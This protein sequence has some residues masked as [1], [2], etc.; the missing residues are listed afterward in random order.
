[1][2]SIKSAKL[3]V[4]LPGCLSPY[5]I[6]GDKLRL[7]ILLSIADNI[8]CSIALTVG[9]EAS[10]NNNPR[11]KERKY[12]PL[13]TD[14][15][16]D[17]KLVKFVHLYISFIGIFGKSSDSVLK[18]CIERC[19]EN[20]DLN[21]IISMLSTIIVGSLYYMFCMRNKAWSEPEFLDY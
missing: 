20:R 21:F 10:S 9:F 19:I 17:Y 14:L 2:R 11:H 15:A 7:V 18:L 1:M 6:T 4:D 8:L 12:R 5:S 13:L 3:Y 16:N